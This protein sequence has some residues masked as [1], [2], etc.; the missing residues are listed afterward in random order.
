MGFG[1]TMDLI[2]IK[3]YKVIDK[4]MMGVERTM[5]LKLVKK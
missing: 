3:K 5:D 4:K 1:K 2:F